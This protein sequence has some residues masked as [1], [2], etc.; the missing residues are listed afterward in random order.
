MVCRVLGGVVHPSLLIHVERKAVRLEIIFIS[1]YVIH[2]YNLFH[3]CYLLDESLE[4]GH[5]LLGL[6]FK[7]FKLLLP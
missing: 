2:C 7:A 1:H 5:G 6:W 4:E 3:Q